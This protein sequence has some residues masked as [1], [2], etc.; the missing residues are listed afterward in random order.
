M[1]L[2]HK[3]LVFIA[4]RKIGVTLWR[5]LIHDLSKLTPTEFSYHT[6][7]YGEI[8]RPTERVCAWIHHQNHN[9]HHWEYWIP[10]SDH[11]LPSRDFPINEPIPMPDW[12]IKEMVADW[13]AA[14]RSLCGEWPTKHTWP[15]LD[16]HY[17][18]IRVHKETR[19]KINILLRKLNLQ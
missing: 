19:K 10:R 2:C 11:H 1:L 4:G 9:P 12:A 15:W 8:G 16:K 6:G 7:F 18:K 13:L 3:W 14:R 5:L 17:A